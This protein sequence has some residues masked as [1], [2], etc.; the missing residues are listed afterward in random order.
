MISR[1]PLFGQDLWDLG[2]NGILIAETE[3]YDPF[4]RVTSVIK[5]SLV[6]YFRTQLALVWV[7][8]KRQQNTT[9]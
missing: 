9:Q 6:I 3:M 8:L 2:P 5:A 4:V 7:I 1:L